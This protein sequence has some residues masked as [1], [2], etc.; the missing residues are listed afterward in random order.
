MASC[1]IVH[2]DNPSGQAYITTTREIKATD[3]LL[4]T[5]MKTGG[6]SPD[7]HLQGSAI[8]HPAMID[9]DATYDVA[10]DFLD[11]WTDNGNY[12]GMTLYNSQ[13]ILVG[14]KDLNLMFIASGNFPSVAY[15]ITGIY[16]I[17]GK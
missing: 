16:N 12:Y 10:L 11:D 7:F 6:R 4:I 5:W 13:E 1:P 14:Q 9:S 8:I 15:S 3:I 2:A 17:S